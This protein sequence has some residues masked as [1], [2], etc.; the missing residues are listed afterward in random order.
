LHVTLL[1]NLG[2]PVEKFGESTGRLNN[3]GD[4]LLQTA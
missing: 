3:L 1:D 2:V 4:S